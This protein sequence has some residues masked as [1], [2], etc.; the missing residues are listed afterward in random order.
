MIT[1]LLLFDIYHVVV[2]AVFNGQRVPVDGIR[3]VCRIWILLQIGDLN[4]G[5]IVSIG[6]VQ[7]IAVSCIGAGAVSVEGI[8]KVGV[9]FVCP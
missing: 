5:S 2:G 6:K 1:S 4:R 7:N 8:D 9:F 3:I